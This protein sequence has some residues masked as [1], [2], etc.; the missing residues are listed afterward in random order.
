MSG[1]TDTARQAARQMTSGSHDDLRSDLVNHGA[2][3]TVAEMGHHSQ[4][5]SDAELDHLCQ[6][7]VHDGIHG[8]EQYA[9][10]GE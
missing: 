10:H 7:L 2:F 4:V 5:L 8:L 9:G 1:D 6:L 3:E